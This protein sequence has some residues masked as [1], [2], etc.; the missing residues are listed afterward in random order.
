[1][2]GTI[3]VLELVPIVSAKRLAAR[4]RGIGL[5]VRAA[6]LKVSHGGED[7]L[8]ALACRGEPALTKS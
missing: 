6:T 3:L 7:I 5:W 8:R 4:V 2:N 1:M